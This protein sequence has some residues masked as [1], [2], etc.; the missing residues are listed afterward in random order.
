MAELS[1]EKPYSSLLEDN[2]VLRAKLKHANE[3]LEE[4]SGPRGQFVY[5]ALYNSDQGINSV[6]VVLDTP[7]Q[8]HTAS[9][10]VPDIE[11]K[12]RCTN[13]IILSFSRMENIRVSPDGGTIQ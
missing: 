6:T 1:H 10:I 11:R 12:E 2:R 13:A 5:Y 7:W 8:P 4:L 9:M 3:T